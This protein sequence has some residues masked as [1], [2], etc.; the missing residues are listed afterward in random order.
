M[1]RYS[2]LRKRPTVEGRRAVIE[3][4]RAGRDIDQILM[5][6]D[7]QLG[8]QLRE[9]VFLANGAGI[10]VDG[11]SRRDLDRQSATRKHQG[12][13]AIVPDTRYVPIEDLVFA[14]DN[15][16]EP[17]LLIMLDGVQDPHNLG[18][19]ART[20][21]AAGGHGIVIPERRAA[22]ISPGAIRASAGALEHVPVARVNN[23]AKSAE[24]LK[25]IGL[26]LIGLEQDAESHYSEPDYTAPTAIVVGSE[27]RGISPGVRSACQSLI[28]IPLRGNMAS[29]NA[30]VAAA[31]VLYEAVR[32]RSG[33]E[34]ERP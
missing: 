5:Q 20:V 31:I 33:A 28:S 21:D 4:L 6:D 18:A 14:A 16:N 13:I 8:P 17:P 27:E 29:L 12:V 19:I 23:V 26:N 11:V 2:R 22:G 9:I 30:S 7:A 15:R 34:R 3:A 1:S 10:E 25:T 24:Y 32:Q